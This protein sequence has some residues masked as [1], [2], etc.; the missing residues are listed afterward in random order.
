MSA[1][2]LLRW[3]PIT[4]ALVLQSLCFRNLRFH[5]LDQRLQLLLAL[6]AGVGIDIAGVLF[7][8]GPLGGVAALEEMVVVGVRTNLDFQYSILENETFCAG[9]ANT[10]FIERFLAGEV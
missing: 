6:L 2:L 10:S 4:F 7:T 9:E 1:S 5:L 8:I 3:S